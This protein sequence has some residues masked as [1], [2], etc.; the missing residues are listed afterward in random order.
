MI[1][2]LRIKQ[3]K[4]SGFTLV[5]LLVGMSIVIMLMLIAIGT[6]NPKVLT[7]K[8]TDSTRKRDLNKIRTAFEEYFNDHGSYPDYKKVDEWNTK[9]NCGKSISDVSSYLRT[10]L[11]DPSGNPYLILI[12][13]NWFKVVTNLMNKKDKDIPDKWYTDDGLIYTT[14]FDKSKVNYGVSSSNILWYEITSPNSGCGSI[15]KKWNASGCND[16]FGIGC[17]P[18]DI[19]YLGSCDAIGICRVTSCKQ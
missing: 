9:L 6:I 8:A 16:T 3:M 13:D 15:C 5:E 17:N 11:C 10:W 7:D 19:C 14:F 1:Y 2:D 4:K 18:P 12:G